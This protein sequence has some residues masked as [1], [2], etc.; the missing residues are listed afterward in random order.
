MYSKYPL[1]LVTVDLLHEGCW[2]SFLDSKVQVIAHHSNGNMVRD[3][4]VGKL[5][6]F[7]V[8]KRLDRSTR[9]NTISNVSY[10]D[11]ER[12]LVDMTLDYRNSIFSMLDTKNVMVLEPTVVYGNEVWSFLAYEYQISEILHDLREASRVNEVEIQDYEGL[13]LSE[14][15]VEVLSAAIDMGYFNIPK[16]SN[17]RDIAKATGKSVNMVAYTL[18][19]GERKVIRGITQLLKRWKYLPRTW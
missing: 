12:V 8:I 9:I 2:T 6:S 14:E 3:L 10:L 16:E 7:R 19:S 5:D 11:S 18:K 15:E 17:L 13:E 1:K 4:V